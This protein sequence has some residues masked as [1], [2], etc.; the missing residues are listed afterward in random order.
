MFGLYCLSNAVYFDDFILIFAA[1]IN[2][3]I[4]S[5]VFIF[6]QYC[7][8]FAS[9]QQGWGAGGERTQMQAVRL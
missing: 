3:L 7:H 2:V 4:C 1:F 5:R 9:R 8:G 6:D